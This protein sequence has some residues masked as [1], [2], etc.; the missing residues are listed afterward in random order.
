[1]TTNIHARH[2][3]NLPN[4]SPQLFITSRNNK[5]SPPRHHLHQTVIS[6]TPLAIAGDT[7]KP[8][9]LGHPQSHFVFGAKFFEFSHNTVG[10]AGDAFGKKT[11][12]HRS[13]D[14][15]LISNG[16]VDKVGVNQD[17]VRRAKLSVVLEE[18][19]RDGLVYVAGFLFG[20]FF[21]EFLLLLLLVGFDAGVF[22]TD[23]LFGYGEFTC[24]F[25]FSHGYCC[26]GVNSLENLT[27]LHD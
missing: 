10:N 11:I 18:E 2:S 14:F 9:V 12:H 4:P 22:G 26:V 17:V 13:N 27:S 25:G 21:G 7:F 15:H 6:I 1:M 5:T 23:D 19:G 24:L 3:R 8:R 20:F 16:K